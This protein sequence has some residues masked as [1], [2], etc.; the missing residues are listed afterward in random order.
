MKKRCF[1]L[2]AALCLLGTSQWAAA[3]TSAIVSGKVTP[4]G[5]PLM[6][7]NRD[8]STDQN[9]VKHFKGEKYSFIAIV[10]SNS[11]NPRSVWMGTND[12]GFS[13]MNTLSYNLKEKKEGES[14]GARNGSV[15]RRALEICATVDDFK[16]FLDTLSQPRKVETNYGVIDARGGA[17]YFETDDYNYTM[18]DVNDP[19]VAPGGYLVRTNYSFAGKLNEGAGHVRYQ[20]AER[21]LSIASATGELTPGWFFSELSRSFANPLMGI[22]LKDGR[23]NKPN[24]TGWFVEQDF[25]AR[26][27]STC[28]AVVQGVKPEENPELTVMWTVIGYPPVTPAVPLWV[29]GDSK[30]LPSL[31]VRDAETKVSPLCDKALILR[32]RVYSY[33]RG[34][35]AE[36]YF[37][38]E[39][40]YNP[41]QTGYI[42][43]I[44]PIEK[45]VI[46][47]TE[48]A[49][50][51][52][53][54]KNGI[55]VT[56]L[57]AL[58]NE[59]NMYVTD[60]YGKL[61]NL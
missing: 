3:C 28:A 55:N 4:D 22:D 1:F 35:D 38:F 40:L 59:L 15:M 11:A 52:W 23:F 45:E 58:Y 27:K 49:L 47:K 41:Q 8:T 20:E 16:H 51:R 44:T 61:F 39:L 6:W 56:E 48:N 14:G 24:T 42:Q 25:I 13:I 17:A 57:Y 36:R 33:T 32:N 21:Q 50:A 2:F 12:A 34:T 7:K 30:K 43:L 46:H 60:Q 10:N 18:Y 53:R 9:C 19:S 37:N 5:R 29:K 54:E 31:L 26:K